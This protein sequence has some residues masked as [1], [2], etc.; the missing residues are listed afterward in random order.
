MTC[1][2]RL[3]V[4]GTDVLSILPEGYMLFHCQPLKMHQLKADYI[5]FDM[6]NE[7]GPVESDKKQLAYRYTRVY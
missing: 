1:T 5:A 6:Y 3:Y 2:T 4:L 7:A